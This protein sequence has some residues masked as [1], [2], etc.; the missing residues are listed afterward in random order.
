MYDSEVGKLFWLNGSCEGRHVGTTV[1]NKAGNQYQYFTIGYKGKSY[2][3][4]E[5][6]V[7]WF[8]NYEKWPKE[9]DHIDGVGTNNKLD[10]LREVTRSENNKNHRLQRNNKI[11]GIAGVRFYANKK[12]PLWQAYSYDSENRKQIQLA[13]FDN[14]FDACCARKSFEA[15]NGFTH[16]H[17]K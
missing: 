12:T 3:F 5:H 11:T 4:L 16:R 15:K 8:L 1:Q 6:V 10:N 2:N 9:I 7:V 13:N 14:F 17:G